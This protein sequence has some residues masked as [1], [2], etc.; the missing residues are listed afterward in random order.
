MASEKIRN[1]KEFDHIPIIAMSAD[2][3]GVIKEKC[4][5]V[6]MNEFILKPISAVSVFEAIIQ[7]IKPSKRDIG[8]LKEKECIL[9]DNSY[10]MLLHSFKIWIKW[11]LC[12]PVCLK[13]TN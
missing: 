9:H 13:L 4:F 5:K 3:V 2:V 1:N 8:T 10:S 7:W 11:K 6:G 12:I